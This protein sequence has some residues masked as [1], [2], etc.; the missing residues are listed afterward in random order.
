MSDATA[1]IGRRFK[2]VCDTYNKL[3]VHLT[4]LF[5]QRDINVAKLASLDQQLAEIDMQLGNVSNPAASQVADFMEG[6]YFTLQTSTLRAMYDF[7]KAI[8][9]AS[10]SNVPLNV[11]SQNINY[12]ALKATHSRLKESIAKQIEVATV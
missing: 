12:P 11:D 9:Y 8:G 1:P 10:L 2:A 7:S 5:M 3:V 6:L 4:D